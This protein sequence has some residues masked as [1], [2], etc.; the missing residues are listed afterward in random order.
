[1]PSAGRALT[2]ARALFT[3]R[4]AKAAPMASGEAPRAALYCKV[5]DFQEAVAK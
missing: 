5:D 3:A 1:M 4:S 2:H